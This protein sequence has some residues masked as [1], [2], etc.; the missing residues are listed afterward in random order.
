[1]ARVLSHIDTDSVRAAGPFLKW[2]GGKTQLLSQLEQFFPV[3]FNSYY[4][5]FVGSAA[6]FFHL[7]RMRGRFPSCLADYNDELVNC[8]RMVRDK[9]DALIPLL[10]QHQ[11]KHSRDYYYSVR[12]RVPD[13]MTELQRAAR[14]IYLNKTCYNGLYRVNSKGQFNVPIGSY[15]KPRIINENALKY[16][17]A[18]LQEVSLKE[19]DFS[20]VLDEAESGDLVYFDPPYHT[21]TSGFTSYAVS[22]SGQAKFGPKEHRRL[23]EVAKELHENGCYIVVSNS[24]TEYIRNL[25]ED[26]NVYTVEA[27]RSIN[28]DGAGRGSVT[29]LVITNG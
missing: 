24:D 9:V 2:A 21:E 14:L 19:C 11:L 25:F 27:R 29:E 6:V 23:L 5:P 4:E 8:Y 13:K 16:A 15:K 10:K 22:S 1:M 7:R 3:K 18:A 26:F 28:S 17:G 12:K 20:K